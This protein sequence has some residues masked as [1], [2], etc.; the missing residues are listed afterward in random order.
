[1]S[2]AN[3]GAPFTPARPGA[4]ANGRD[5]RSRWCP[6]R[7]PRRGLACG[8]ADGRP[9]QG[10][11]RCDSRAATAEAGLLHL[12]QPHTAELAEQLTRLAGDS[13]RVGQVA[14]ILVGD[15]GGR[16]GPRAEVG[17]GLRQVRQ[18]QGV[19]ARS[20]VASRTRAA[21]AA[22]RSAYSGS[23]WSR[24]QY[25]FSVAPQPAAL[26]ATALSGS[27]SNASMLRRANSRAPS[28]SP[29]WALRARS[30]PVPPSR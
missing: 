11:A 2:H 5:W 29:L 1:M 28:R 4:G 20:S 6:R 22:A 23:S 13:L 26:I 25:S 12:D 3:C 30:S 7:L 14:G 9:G 18:R 17:T 21:N 27:S 24:W 15:N 8:R 10:G 19:P 16:V